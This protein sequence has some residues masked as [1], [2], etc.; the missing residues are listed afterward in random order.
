MFR[1]LTGFTLGTVVGAFAMKY[2]LDN[3]YEVEY[4]DEDYEEVNPD[5]NE[6]DDHPVDS[7]EDKEEEDMT[8]EEYYN[9]GIRLTE[10]YN[11]NKN[12]KPRIIS[13]K[14]ID[15]LPRTV[16]ERE[17]IY[18]TESMTLA[19]GEDLSI[20]DNPEFFVGDCLDKYGFSENSEDYIYVMNYSLNVLYNVTKVR[21]EYDGPFKVV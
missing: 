11:K 13:I 6:T 8:A 17:L 18:Y 15:N 7:D 14:D 9:E 12:K 3:R 5:K 19:D 20:I 16:E 2:Y 1:F 21:G 4:P 10:E